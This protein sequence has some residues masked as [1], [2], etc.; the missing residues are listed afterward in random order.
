MRLFEGYQLDDVAQ[1]LPLGAVVFHRSNDTQF[2]SVTYHPLHQDTHG[3][4]VLP[5]QP[6]AR[7]EA[8]GLLRTLAGER[9]DDLSWI[10]PNVLAQGEER[11]AWFV[12]G[13]I[14]P[15]LFRGDKGH[16]LSL[17]V[18]WPTLVF[19]ARAGQIHVAALSSGRRPSPRSRLFHAPLWNTSRD[20]AVCLGSATVPEL[21][22]FAAMAGFEEAIFETL[23]SHPNF[24]GNLRY[25]QDSHACTS[26]ANYLRF[27]RALEKSEKTVFPKDRLVPMVRTLG[28]FLSAD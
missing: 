12:P 24:A 16:A 23:F 26:Q 13:R 2:T 22:G 21:S 6:M 18:P 11:L 4:Q 17:N 5:G 20:G 1:D 10:P 25:R 27:W 3:I 14:R 8:M 28:E 19:N 7:A 9:R 15:M